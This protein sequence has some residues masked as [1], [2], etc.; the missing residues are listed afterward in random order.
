[1]DAVEY[2]S[3]IAPSYEA[4]YKEEQLEKIKRI[5]SLVPHTKS[6]KVLDIGAGTGLLEENLRE[7]KIIAL[8]PSEMAD[9]LE[10]KKLPNVKVLRLKVSQFKSDEKFD[11]VFCIT[12][13]QD[14][15]KAERERCIKSAFAF[16][17][18]GGR[19]VISVLEASKIDL[20]YLKPIL[21]EKVANDKVYV[22]G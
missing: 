16:C 5:V 4:L 6:S 18:H 2:Y 9:F 14:L 22:F 11:L 8:E 15:A 7:C 13:L 1:M 17:K 21:T 12:V 20:G 3:S 10:A 19:I